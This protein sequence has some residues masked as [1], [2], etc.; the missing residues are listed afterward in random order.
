MLRHLQLQSWAIVPG[1]G[2]GWVRGREWGRGWGVMRV[3]CGCQEE[4]LYVC[5]SDTL[6]FLALSSSCTLV[7][8]CRIYQ[9]LSK[10]SC[11][12]QVRTGCPHCVRGLGW[13]VAPSMGISPRDQTMMTCPQRSP[14]SEMGNMTQDRLFDSPDGA[15]A[16]RANPMSPRSN[17]MRPVLYM[18]VLIDGRADNCGTVQ[19]QRLGRVAVQ[20]WCY[21]AYAAFKMLAE[22]FVA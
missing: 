15:S 3:S 1:W 7:M 14:C 13:E 11:S 19:Q 18:A 10:C 22:P 8:A 9:R 17:R 16:S 12:D 2:W 21:I 4:L 6:I 5:M 20:R